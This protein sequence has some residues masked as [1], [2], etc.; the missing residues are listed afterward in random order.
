MKP[1][2]YNS[3]AKRELNRA[4]DYYDL[5]TYVTGEDFLHA[6]EDAYVEIQKA[7]HLNAHY[8]GTPFRKRK[9]EQ[10]PYTIFFLETPSCIW[11]AAI[12][13]HKR[14]PGYWLGRKGP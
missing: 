8:A 2:R 6:V 4:I 10:F 1:I 12:S 13:H 9:L 7:P 3:Q 5:G 11:V 14:K